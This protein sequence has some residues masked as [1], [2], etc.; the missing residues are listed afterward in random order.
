MIVCLT[1]PTDV[2]TNLP[3][4]GWLLTS[5]DSSSIQRCPESRPAIRH[6]N[7]AGG[8]AEGIHLEC[9]IGDVGVGVG[10]RVQAEGVGGEVA[11]GGGVV[12]AVVVVVEAG[13]GVPVLPGE[14]ERT[15]DDDAGLRGRG[16][17]ADG[18]APRG[19]TGLPGDRPGGGEQFG[20]GADE[21]G[22][23]GVE[24]V[25][26]FGL[27]EFAPGRGVVLA[28]GDSRVR[29][30][31]P[32]GGGP[33]AAVLFGELDAVPGEGGPVGRCL[34]GAC[35]VLGRTAAEGVVGVVPGGA[36]GGGGLG[37]V[38]EGVP[39]VGPGAGAA[40]QE[41]GA[42]VG[43]AS[44]G[45]VGVGGASGAEEEG[46][47]QDPV[48]LEG[49]AVVCARGPAAAGISSDAG[50]CRGPGAGFP[51]GEVIPRPGFGRVPGG[52]SGGGQGLCVV[53]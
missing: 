27:G 35:A 40:R 30:A 13:F 15:I 31:G 10:C 18:V 38:V 6:I 14:A 28:E 16:P 21:V 20:G 42:A 47:A 26:H 52:G 1:S 48:P 7:I 34:V 37:E 45:V 23:D 50:S 5:R 46:S 22:D 4:M 17:G 32:G 41:S 49:V 24:A 44:G 53:G 25:V 8:E 9:R 11:G 2:V 3:L 19:G 39:G 33:V 12:V 36:V 29:V 43:E 51:A